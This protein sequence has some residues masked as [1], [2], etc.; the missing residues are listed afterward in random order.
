LPAG[1]GVWVVNAVRARTSCS[2]SSK[3]AAPSAASSRAASSAANAAWP[4][5]DAP[6]LRGDV[7]VADRHRDRQRLAAVGIVD[8][9][10]RR[11]L[12]VGRDPELLL[13]AGV[14]DALAEVAAAVHEPDRD[15]RQ[16]VVGGLL[17]DVAGERA[18]AA[19]VD[20]E[21]AVEAVLGREVGDRA[22][23]AG[24]RVVGGAREVGADAVLER[25]RAG[26][27]A[28]VGR[29]GD[30]PRGVGLLQ[31]LDGVLGDAVPAV[32]VEGAEQ[33]RPVRVPRP[34]V[35]VGDAGEDAQRLGKASGE[36]L[37]G[38]L[39]IATACLHVG[40]HRSSGSRLA[41]P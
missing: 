22:L 28:L 9:H 13:P 21:R 34:A 1:T 37:G 20:R 17:E 16:A 19:G 41:R 11:A 12:G 7:L 38:S 4:D 14:V 32:G 35:V 2:A 24:D 25:R 39:E 33:V 36:R 15:E 31:E 23:G 40:Q 5:V 8:E 30:E 26:E 18:E 6:D 10:G 3:P 27:Q 29:G